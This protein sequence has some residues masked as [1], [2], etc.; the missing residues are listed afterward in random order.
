MHYGRKPQTFRPYVCTYHGCD[1][2]HQHRAGQLYVQRSQKLPGFG[3]DIR[4]KDCQA[5][6]RTKVDQH[7]PQA[8]DTLLAGARLT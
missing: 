5:I 1:I 3:I 4:M 8:L 2:N 6:Q 7:L